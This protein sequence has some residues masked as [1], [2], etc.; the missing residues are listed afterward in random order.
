[1][2]IWSWQHVSVIISSF[3]FIFANLSPLNLSFAQFTLSSLIAYTF[4]K[5]TI[6]FIGFNMKHIYFQKPI[7]INFNFLDLNHKP[8]VLSWTLLD[9]VLCRVLSFR[10]CQFWM[11]ICLAAMQG[12]ESRKNDLA[13]HPTLKWGVIQYHFTQR[14][15]APDRFYPILWIES[16]NSKNGLNK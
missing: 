16:Y 1:M 14:I 13:V 15:G 2:R 10:F 11:W 7:K 5:H 4:W 8:H 3:Q 12:W 9:L 6:A